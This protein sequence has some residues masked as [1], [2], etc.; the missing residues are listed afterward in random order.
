[1]LPALSGGAS[2]Y[3][4]FG[5]AKPVTGNASLTHA[6]YDLDYNPSY[7]YVENEIVGLADVDLY[8]GLGTDAGQT[9]FFLMARM[10][11]TETVPEST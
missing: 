5:V 9:L 2:A 1:M 6:I 3:T 4:S 7:S 8:W 11:L 10:D